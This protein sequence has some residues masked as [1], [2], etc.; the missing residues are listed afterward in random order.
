[1]VKG[2]YQKKKN[3]IKIKTVNIHKE[4]VKKKK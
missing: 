2:M 4:M 3:N 1:M